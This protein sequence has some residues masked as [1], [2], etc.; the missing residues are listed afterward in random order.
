MNLLK[1]IS[2]QEI[3]P[4]FK[5][6]GERK[7]GYRKAVRGV[8]FDIENKV[9]LI[10]VSKHNYY[11]LP[12]GGVEGSESDEEVLRRECMEELGCDVNIGLEVGSI[13]E[14]RDKIN[15]D[16]ESFCYLAKISGNK[17]KPEL[18]GYEIDYGF[19]PVWVSIDEA[20]ELAENSKPDTYDGPFI[21]IRDLVFLKKAK[22]LIEK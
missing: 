19:E 21:K 10:N 2:E 13:F 8:V 22:E 4:D 1:T 7:N 3:Y 16:Q 9:G 18:I 12:G 14:H 17:G 6:E 11:K 5:P 15:V 20:I